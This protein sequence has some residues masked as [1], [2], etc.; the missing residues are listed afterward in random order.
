MS[1]RIIYLVGPHA[2]VLAVINECTA[3]RKA[4]QIAALAFRDKY[5]AKDVVIG[6]DSGRLWGLTFEGQAP[7]GWRFNKA[8]YY[9]P[10][11]RTKRGKEIKAEIEALPK[12]VSGL[13]FSDRL[14]KEFGVD[15]TFF[16]GSTMSWATYGHV[17]DKLLLSI[18]VEIKFVPEGCTELKV[19]EY[20][21]IVKEAEES[22]A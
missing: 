15:F 20:Q 16:G 11:L 3:T 17:G 4:C 22:A 1:E 10:S 14:S 13:G 19:S 21:Q 8:N 12:A 18:P 7:E 9:V 6:T 5:K 2:P